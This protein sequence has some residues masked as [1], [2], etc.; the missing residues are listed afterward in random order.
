MHHLSEFND[1]EF[2]VDNVLLK[3]KQRI[4][5]QLATVNDFDDYADVVWALVKSKKYSRSG[6]SAAAAVAGMTGRLLLFHYILKQGKVYPYLAGSEKKTRCSQ[7]TRHYIGV[8][9]EAYSKNLRFIRLLDHVS[10]WGFPSYKR[11]KGLFPR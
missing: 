11:N 10:L 5:Y 2:S 3:V 4:E 7:F 6:R 1:E 9:N 8:L